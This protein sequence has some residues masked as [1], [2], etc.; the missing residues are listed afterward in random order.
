MKTLLGILL[1]IFITQNSLFA[2]GDEERE[3]VP[4]PPIDMEE[5]YEIS[6]GTWSQELADTYAKALKS[7]EFTSA[8]PNISVKFVVADFSGH[9]SRAVTTI[10]AGE[11]TNEIEML[12]V[13]QIAK[14]VEGGGLTYLDEAPFNGFEV[15][16]DVVNFAMGNAT[17]G[18]GKLVAFPVDIAP[19]VMFYRKSLTDAAGVDMTKIA[20]WDEFIEIGKKLTFDSDGDGEI[21]QFA[22]THAVEVSNVP[23][24]GGMA[25]WF[26]AEGEPLQPKAKFIESLELVDMVRKAGIDGDLGTWS[27]PW[28]Q[29]FADGRVAVTI[30]GA[31]FGGGLETW[32]APDTAGD[33]RVAYI[34]GQ[35][36]ASMGGSYFTIPYKVPVEKKAAAWEVIKFLSTSDT[37]QL[38]SF[39]EQSAFPVIQTLYTHPV[40]NE[41]V[42]FFGGQKVRQIYADVAGKM[43]NDPVSE[44]DPV[45]RAIFGNATTLVLTEGISPEEAYQSSLNELLAVIE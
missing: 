22:I 29:A 32:I 5:N 13:A 3:S 30:N 12:E 41:E 35:S 34:P 15:G 28:L 19:A 43:P 10:A 1:L 42:A 7:S 17:S 24:N 21:D 11:A 37:A 8:F 6:I 40:M 36:Y 31:W 20:T 2:N 38:A 4:V 33:W 23:L 45:A 16:K 18:S 44:F 26:N 27:P 9:H 14:F 25:G 39:R